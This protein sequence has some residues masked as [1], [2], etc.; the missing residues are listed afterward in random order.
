MIA[1]AVNALKMM[2]VLLVLS[3]LHQKL[4]NMVN[5]KDLTWILQHKEIN[6]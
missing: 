3:A 5:L 1:G 2:V 6:I 4:M